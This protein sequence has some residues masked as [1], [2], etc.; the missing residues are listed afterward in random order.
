[1]LPYAVL[2]C[3]VLAYIVDQAILGTPTLSE[4]IWVLSSSCLRACVARS[5]LQ[6][7]HAG[8]STSS[9]SR[10]DS[11][12][13]W[14]EPIG[15][16]IRTETK[17]TETTTRPPHEARYALKQCKPAFRERHPQHI[18]QKKPFAAG[19]ALARDILN[20]YSHVSDPPGRPGHVKTNV[21]LEACSTNP[22]VRDPQ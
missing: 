20:T 11:A 17:R 15:G 13:K 21:S 2:N 7:K 8:R 22:H 10:P 19:E 4:L 16:R 9:N 5:W 12:T 6:S 18:L 14:D 1:M 3:A